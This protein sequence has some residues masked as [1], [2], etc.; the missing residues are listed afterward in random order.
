MPSLLD[1][2]PALAPSAIPIT[3]TALDGSL[4]SAH[5]PK[6]MTIPEIHATVTEYAAAAQRALAAGFDGVEIHAANGYLL[7]QFLHDNVNTRTDEYGGSV[8][9]RARIVLEVITAVSKA[10]GSDRVGVRL[11]PYNYFQDTRDSDPQAHWVEV[12]ELIAGLEDGV[13]PA[14]VHMVE[15][16]FDEVLD[17]SAKMSSLPGGGKAKPN[18]DIFRGPLKSA[19]VGFIAAGAFQGENAKGKIDGDGADAVAFGRWFIAN[20]DLPR[21]LLEGAK[22]NQYDRTTFYGAD[23]AE[24]GYTDYS[25]LV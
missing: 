12:C 9:N 20:P 14:Y 18:L 19:G 15:P 13:R 17:E 25:A 4:Y 8:A 7:D 22:L 23:P 5:P 3:G 2:H 11:S 16:R 10:I 6:P 1:G 21:R 24:K